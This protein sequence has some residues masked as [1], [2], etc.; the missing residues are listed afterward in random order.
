MLGS[1]FSSRSEKVS[2]EGTIHNL[3]NAS[4]DTV[5]LKHENNPSGV[6]IRGEGQVDVYSGICRS[7]LGIDGLFYNRSK[8]YY[9]KSDLSIFNVPNI[10]KFII[11]GKSITNSAFQGQYFSQFITNILS[12]LSFVDD[13]NTSTSSGDKLIGTVK[14]LDVITPIQIFEDLVDKLPSSEKEIYD[15]LDGAM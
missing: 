10:S 9:N 2:P 8:T 14:L 4:E 1:S 3:L 15:L 11:N 7:I 13:A 5:Y 6:A 12:N